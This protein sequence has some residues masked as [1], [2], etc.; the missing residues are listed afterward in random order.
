MSPTPRAAR[1][2]RTA[3]Q[4]GVAAV[5]RPQG[6]DRYRPPGTR[7]RYRALAVADVDLDTATAVLRAPLTPPEHEAEGVHALVWLHGVPVG[8]LTVPGPPDVVL[9]AL[10][11]RAARELEQQVLEHL[12]LDALLVPGGLRAAL[13]E[14]LE[15]VPHPA[16][17]ADPPTLT[18]AVCT[19]DRPEDLRRC[20]ASIARLQG[21]VAEVLVV[22]NASRDERTRLVAEEFGARYV[23][24]PR[25][26]LDWAR[27]RALLEA[28]AEVVAFA[29]DDVLVHPRWAAELA[30]TFAE[31]PDAV[32]VTGLVA[33]A[34]FSTPAQVLFEAV[35]GFGRGYR[36]RWFSAAVDSGEVAARRHPGTGGAGTGAST[37]L[38]RERALALGGFDTALDVGTPTGGGGDL[39]VYFRVL[40]AG[41]LVVYEPAAVVL[42]RHRT[43][44]DQLAR[45]LRGNGTGAYSIFAGASGNYGGVQAAELGAF[46]A[47]WFVRQHARAHLRSLVWPQLYPP[48]LTRA[49]TRGAVDAVLGRY[50]RAARRQAAAEAA[51]HP[52][53]PPAP[54][55]VHRPAER[56]RPRRADPVVRVD[57]LEGGPAAARLPDGPPSPGQRR[58]RVL[59]ERAG[60]PQAAFAVAAD[61]SRVGTAR[62]ARELVDRLGPALLRP[63]TSWHDL[64]AAGGGGARPLAAALRTALAAAPERLPAEVPVSVLMA[65]RDRPRELRRSLQALLAST[66]RPLQVV[67]VDNSPDP[68]ATR[69]V[70]AGLPGVQVVHEPWPG[71]SPARNAGLAHLRGDVVV[72]VDDDVETTAG[73]LEE[74]L[75]P[76]ADPAV[77]AVTGNVVPA[78]LD[79]LD[80]QVFEDYGGLGRGPHR[81]TYDR[82]WLVGSRGPAPTWQI[83]ATANAAV[84]RDV[85]AGLGPF[86]ETLGPGRPSGVGEDTEYFYRVLRSGWTI[87]YQPTAVVRH[88]HRAD[89]PGL[90]RQVRA[91]SSGHVAYH[92]QVAA[93]HGDVRGLGRV[94]VGVPRHLAR[95]AV[96][97]A[98]GRDDYPADVLATEVRGLLEGPSAWWRS[99]RSA[100]EAGRPVPD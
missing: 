31:E 24:E 21:P 69:A 55:L 30:R 35:G 83:G 63:G 26:G 82:S 56:R 65:T 96:Q 64:A 6:L 80:P 62:L 91:Y 70:A 3:L 81:R 84:R 1:L 43:G 18:V 77:G 46:A 44:M 27:N 54:A 98:R 5:R 9:G 61:G 60:A 51:R 13:A 86:D 73:W 52:G 100:Q 7:R 22:D 95:R 89:R 16:P 14:G 66:A 92:L 58:L 85:L 48:E 28:R 45:Q 41:G 94:A 25:A 32:V 87:V 8:D 72:L 53:E 74:L 34:E 75:A 36:R 79:L 40:A 11:A 97:V 19:R 68:S 49:D 57:L 2:A 17:P 23:R 42:H 39:E 37:A 59:V 15:H 50:Y 76:F 12:L 67:V 10:P 47:R 29:D 88:H 20:L 71:L 90:R 33:P 4:Q 78:N 99:R 38:R 93:R